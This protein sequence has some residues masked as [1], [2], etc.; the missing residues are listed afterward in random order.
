MFELPEEHEEGKI[1][2]L[3]EFQLHALLCNAHINLLSPV[4]PEGDAFFNDEV[5]GVQ[6]T[7]KSKSLRGYGAQ[8]DL[9]ELQ[10]DLLGILKQLRD[11]ERRCN[12]VFDAYEIES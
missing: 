2:E 6:L 5:T 9:S 1:V 10:H 12:V 11:L 3:D 7:P 4:L 8:A